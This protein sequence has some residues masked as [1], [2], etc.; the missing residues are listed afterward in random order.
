[1]QFVVPP[2]VSQNIAR[3]KSLLGRGEAVRALGALLTAIDLFESAGVVG[4]ARSGTEIALYECVDTCNHNPVIKKLIR[5]IAKS[6][7]AVIAYKPGEEKKLAA[8]LT[9]IR[10]ALTE[11]EAAKAREAED[12]HRQRREGLFEEAQKCFQANEAPKARALLRRLGDEFGSEPG[13]LASIGHT[14]SEAGFLPDAVPYFEQ[15]IA[16]F[17]RDSG[18]YS[19]LTNGYLAL[20]EYE[21][22]EKLYLAAIREFGA[23][24]R[25][26]TNLGKLYVTWNKRDKAFEVLN[27]AIR[28]D[29][30]NEET[31][32]LL[33]KVNR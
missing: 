10:K 26:L 32:E 31:Q 27:Q 20:K 25:T 8:V 5:E 6:D 18:P 2:S 13:I 11:A 29:P 16:D 3:A 28:L 1:M 15:A 14:L 30:D 19:E 9:L 24:P 17:P 4:R 33:A 12:S 7:K 23:H 22:A 21:K